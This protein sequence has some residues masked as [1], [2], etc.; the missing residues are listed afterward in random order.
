M[1]LPLN[2]AKDADQKTYTF[3]NHVAPHSVK[4]QRSQRTC[5]LE[6]AAKEDFDNGTVM[7]K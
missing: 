6:S 2:V 5:A 4:R 3:V 7:Q 1:G